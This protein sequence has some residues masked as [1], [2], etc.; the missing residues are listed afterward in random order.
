MSAVTLLGE[1]YQ[2]NFVQTCVILLCFQQRFSL[3]E[4]CDVKALGEPAVDRGKQV[5][6]QS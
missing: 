2:R 1:E 4:G 3:S 5:L 6:V